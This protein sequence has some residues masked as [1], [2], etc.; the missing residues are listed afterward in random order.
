MA[1]IVEGVALLVG[2]VVL[3]VFIAPALLLTDAAFALITS[4]AISVGTFGASLLIGGIAQK[5]Q[6][7]ASLPFSTRQPAAARQI[8]YGQTRVTGTYAF[9]TAPKPYLAGVIV[10]AGHPIQSIDSIY[11]DG[12]KAVPSDGTCDSS[13][14]VDD[15]GNTYNLGGKV[16]IRHTTGATPNTYFSELGAIDSHWDSSCRLDG[17]A[18]SFVRCAFD[19]TIFPQQP[20]IV[21]NVHGKKDIYDPRTGT[22]G[23]TNNAALIIADALCNAEFGVGC[24]YATE[25]DEAQLV[26]AANISDESVVLAAGG[27]ESRY[28]INGY[29]DTDST[30]GEI[31]DAMLASCEGRLTYV[32]GRFKIYPAAFYGSALIFDESALIGGVRWAS[33]RKTRDKINAVRAT[34]ISPKYPYASV[35]FDQDHKDASI[36]SGQ[37]QPTDIPEYAQDADHGYVSDAN[38]TA[39][40]GVKL[41]G[42]RAYR[43][44]TSVSM[45]QRLAKIYLMRNRMQGSGTLKMGLIAYEAQ[46]QDVIQVIFGGFN[47]VSQYLE[48]TQVRFSRTDGPD[49]GSAPTLTVELDVC[50]TDPSVYLW[51][52]A[53]ER[54]IENT[55]S[56]SASNAWGV[57][58]PTSLVLESGSDSAVQGADGIIIPRIHVTWI[59]P[60]D[61]F[62]LSGGHIEMQI[63]NMNGILDYTS[64]GNLS[65]A[66]TFNF[67]TG[68]V[69]GGIYY[70]RVRSVRSNG[71]S[72]I[73]VQAGP[74]TVSANATSFTAG[75]ISGLGALATRNF[76]DFASGVDVI[77]KLATNMHYSTGLTVEDLIPAESGSERTAGKSLDVLADGSTYARMKGNQL[78][79][80]YA[81]GKSHGNNML[82][83]PSF[84]SNFIG[85][86]MDT[87]LLGNTPVCDEWNLTTI[88]DLIAIFN[89]ANGRS[90]GK[91]LFFT[92]PPSILLRGTTLPAGQARVTSTL[93]PI[94][95]G[96][97]LTVSGWMN[98]LANQALPSGCGLIQRIGVFFYDSNRSLV[99]EANPVDEGWIGD[100]V[101]IINVGWRQKKFSLFSPT[102]ACYVAIEC[103]LFSVGA[104][105]VTPSTGT[106][107][108]ARF[109]DISIV[110][111]FES[112]GVFGPQGSILPSQAP[113]I[114]FTVTNSAATLSWGATSMLRSDGS[115]ISIP[116]GSV[117]YTGLSSSTTYYTYWYVDV[118]SSTYQRTNGNPPPSSPDSVMA[119]QT[120]LDGR[121]SVGP[122][123]F[124]TLAIGNPGSGSGTGGGGDTCPEFSE[125]V[126]VRGKGQIHA[127]DVVAGDM[128]KGKSFHGADDVYRK[129]VQVAV[130][131]CAAW[132]IVEGHKLTPCEPIYLNNSWMPAYRAPGSTADHSVSK[133]VLISVDTDEH[134]E[135]N[136]YLVGGTQLLIHNEYLPC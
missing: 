51:S 121:V 64:L 93:I 20:G 114:A 22:R 68:V 55:A 75:D 109:D 70:V 99:S 123:S 42:T 130:V 119:I 36:W 74:H 92:V 83:N 49:E 5:L 107:L 69:V 35:G 30:P 24:D 60:D 16:L 29:F 105:T 127:G 106:C 53:E 41:Y 45:A 21:A 15:N 13:D 46:P 125:L 31:I 110:Q 39:D 77:N 56:P 50:E 115:T 9:E 98:T 58:P 63:F 11:L 122:I 44:T 133:K 37:W 86:P 81:F 129:V 79:E 4:A 128:I 126:D 104:D 112:S 54:G 117:S 88:I 34:F 23:Y 97:G 6:P 14:H 47:W 59:E 65:S 67:I 2:A 131:S 1:K 73:W 120:G 136:Y 132:R 7:G 72:S 33:D 135:Q 57:N 43:F 38:L 40:R 3:G 96:V 89:S 82:G 94:I 108:D 87:V 10:W 113:V 18:A 17:C 32:G 84:E 80:G 27:T 61:P 95:P 25:I 78:L 91:C 90:T 12:R 85:A 62:V 66:V 52:T 71:A 100:G 8:V 28:T 19:A 116:S 111:Q 26:A 103:G 118:A 124:Q 134:D 102:N 76:V 48:V 101:T